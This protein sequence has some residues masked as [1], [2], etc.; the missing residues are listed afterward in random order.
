MYR[1]QPV[2]VVTFT[3]NATRLFGCNPTWKVCLRMT[4]INFGHYFNNLT[5]MRRKYFK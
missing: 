3:R 5:K 2:K 1:N 4:E